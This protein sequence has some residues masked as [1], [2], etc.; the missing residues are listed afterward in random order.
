MRLN[1]EGDTDKQIAAFDPTTWTKL[2]AEICMN[3]ANAKLF[4][5]I[6]EVGRVA[7]LVRLGVMSHAVAVDH[8][9]G[10][11]AYNQ[12]YYEYGA[13][14]IQSVISDAFKVAA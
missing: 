3:V 7:E 11:A 9:H 1:L 4:A 6:D 5:F 13:D 2:Q 14:Q 12:L 10:A 8:L